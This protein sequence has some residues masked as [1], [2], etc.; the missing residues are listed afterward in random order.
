METTSV[1]TEIGR[2]IRL[3]GGVR[4]SFHLQG[5]ACDTTVEG[6]TPSQ[7][8]EKALEYGFTGVGIYETFTHLDLGTVTDGKPRV[9]N[10]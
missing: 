9:W 7:V 5:L 2:K 8:A 10:T 1:D 3:V 6:L 4:H